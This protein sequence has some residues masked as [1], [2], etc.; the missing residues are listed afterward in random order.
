MVV[1][2]GQDNAPSKGCKNNRLFIYNKTLLTRVEG[3]RAK[4][5]FREASRSYEIRSGASWCH[6]Q[7]LVIIM[8]RL[9][10]SL[11]VFVGFLYSSLAVPGLYFFLEYSRQVRNYSKVPSK[12]RSIAINPYQHYIGWRVGSEAGFENHRVASRWF[13]KFTPCPNTSHPALLLLIQMIDA[14]MMTFL[15]S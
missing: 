2:A 8:M 3:G 7:R 4:H 14:S 15:N 11:A 10:Y 9:Q 13:E 5:R 1:I 6:Q 12:R